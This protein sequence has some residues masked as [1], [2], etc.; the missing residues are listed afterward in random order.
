LS[1]VQAITPRR[2]GEHIALDGKTLRGSADPYQGQDAIK[3]ISAYAVDS[4]LRGFIICRRNYTR[5]A[6]STT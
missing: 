3:M 2:V 5:I 4:G 6:S 1:W